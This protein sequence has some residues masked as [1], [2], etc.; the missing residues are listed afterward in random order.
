MSEQI[1]LGWWSAGV[2]SAVAC[3]ISLDIYDN[4]Q[5]YYIETGSAHSDNARFKAECEK[6]YGQEIMT[7]QNRKGYKDH[8]D[9]ILK[10]RYVNGPDG[11]KCTQKLKK[12]VRYQLED[13]FKPT[14]FNHTTIAS[15]IFGFEFEKKEVNRA[16][17][18]LQEYPYAN[19]LFPL[20][21]KGL[22][23][24]N[25]AGM[26]LSAGIELPVMYRLGFNNNNCIGCVKGGM[27]YWNK[28]RIHFPDEFKRM[29]EAERNVGHSCIKDVFLD[30]LNP[31]SGRK[32]KPIAPNCAHFCDV[33]GADIPHK[34]LESIMAG[35]VSIYDVVKKAG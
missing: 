12:E 21:E 23:K 9:V 4:V 11:V 13:Q 3:K 18:F 15:Q 8:I 10:E 30:E 7:I 25:C 5:L 29:A 1:R 6:W 19:A 20:I 16:I 35:V 28:I 26:L 27:A 33:E 34:S 2:T 14:L 22:T 17:R 32:E 31:E 24:D